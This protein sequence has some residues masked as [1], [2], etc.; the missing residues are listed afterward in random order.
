MEESQLRQFTDKALALGMDDARCVGVTELPIDPTLTDYCLEC[1]AYGESA[2]CPP[3]RGAIEDVPGMLAGYEWAV[4]FKRDLPVVDLQSKEY[5]EVARQIHVVAAQLEKWARMRGFKSAGLA[6][7]S[8]KRLFCANSE[9]CQAL[10]PGGVCRFPQWSRLSLSALGVNVFELCD[11][12]GWPIEKVTR[13][14]KHPSD[15]MGVLV[16]ILLVGKN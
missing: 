1:G 12:I 3:H 2:L 8:C 5:L 11:K 16:G 13:D 6:A 10:E 15:A 14:S 7:G 9:T 4:V